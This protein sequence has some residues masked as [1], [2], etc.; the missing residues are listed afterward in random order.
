MT[1]TSIRKALQRTAGGAEFVN[2]Q[3]IKSCM[4]WGNERTNEV[5]K[6]LDFIRRGRTR[7]YAAEEVAARI[8]EQTEV[9]G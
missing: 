3:H 6:G 5:V 9:A 8:Y 1:K 2:R 7:Q 4:G